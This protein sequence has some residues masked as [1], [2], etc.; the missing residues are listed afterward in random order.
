[1]RPSMHANDCYN[2]ITIRP[3][4]I[5]RAATNYTIRLY[6]ALMLTLMLW[7][8][9]SLLKA[10]SVTVTITADNGYGFGFGDAN[11][12]YSG[13]YFGGIRITA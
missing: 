12:I 7:L 8:P 3:S 4:S 11:G 10:D 13:Q 5:R 6:R 2:R 9:A 1:M